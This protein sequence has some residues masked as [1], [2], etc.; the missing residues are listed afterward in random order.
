MK[1]LRQVGALAFVITLGAAT[2]L[3]QSTPPPSTA[4]PQPSA[5]VLHYRAYLAARQARDFRKA[6][7][8]GV[9]ALAAAE[10][11]NNPRTGVLAFNLATLRAFDLKDVK[12]ARQPAER[13]IAAGGDGVSAENA[14]LLVLLSDLPDDHDRVRRSLDAALIAARANAGADAD[15]LAR[16]ASTWG[17]LAVAARREDSALDAFT[18]AREFADRMPGESVLDRAHA[19]IEMGAILLMRERPADA[20]DLF[21]EAVE[22]L[23]PLAPESRGASFPYPELLFGEALTWRGVAYAKADQTERRR[24]KRVTPLTPRAFLTGVAPLCD[25]ELVTE[26]KPKFP[27]P[28]QDRLGI[29]AVTVRLSIGPDGA[30]RR[31]QVVGAVPRED[32]TAAV[33]AVAPQWRMT[34][35]ESRP[36]CRRDTDDYLV[37]IHFLYRN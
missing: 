10:A 27:K 24:M 9:A 37:P 22:M 11:A 31:V 8:E 32:F 3:A 2:A 5:V 14:R 18:H 23:T 16:L 4:A 19:R 13:A 35:R 17:Y 29:G 20:H 34:W 25:G 30:M 1:L 12:G 15:F 21:T 26:P 28:A 36:G 7:A 6:E 33:T